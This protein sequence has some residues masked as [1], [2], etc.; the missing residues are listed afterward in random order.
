MA[1]PTFNDRRQ[2]PRIAF[3]SPATITVG[4]HTVAASAR[5]ISAS[6]LFFFTDVPLV[7]GGEIEIVLVLPEERGLPFQGMIH[8]HGRVVR[9]ESS[10]GQ[11]YG[12][13]VRIESL[14]AVPQ[15]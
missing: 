6:G 4:Q 12:I 1:T 13:G 2:Q 3:K 7:A 9:T 5:D 10:G 14:V 11:Q 8:C 15:S